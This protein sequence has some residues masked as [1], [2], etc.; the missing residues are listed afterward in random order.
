MAITQLEKNYLISM[1]AEDLFG[2]G[3]ISNLY[4]QYKSF[5]EIYKSNPVHWSAI[6]KQTKDK[7]TEQKK[8]LN[9]EKILDQLGKLDV[10]V[11][12]YYDDEYPQLLREIASPPVILYYI[13]NLEV[14]KTKSLAI[15]GTRMISSYGQ[16]VVNEIVPSLVSAD[17][18]VTS[19]FQRGVDQAAHRAALKSGGRTIAVLGTGLD[20]DYPSN[21]QSLK[22]NIIESKSLIMSEFPL[23]TV[24]FKGNFPRRN[25]IVSGLSLGV[26]VVEAAIKSGSMITPRCAVDQNREV[27]AVPGSIFSLLSEGPH[28]LIQQGAKC[29]YSGQDILYELGLVRSEQIHDEVVL[30]NEL[31]KKI[32]EEISRNPS[33]VDTLSLKLDTPVEVL[34]TELTMLELQE[35]INENTDGT[36]SR[37]KIR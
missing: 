31:Q 36:Y 29:V 22:Q 14:L 21:S 16:Q 17:V 35:V 15:V 18:T 7:W 37:S 1:C 4:T 23:G 11:L 30:E 10:K 2:F 9:S 8:H 3:H 5:E 27:F 25:R 19:G 12:T 26:L 6:T 34:S 13:G 24:G 28:Y 20:V 32:F 33:S